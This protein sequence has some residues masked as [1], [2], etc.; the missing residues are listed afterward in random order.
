MRRGGA[1]RGPASP[2]KDVLEEGSRRQDDGRTRRAYVRALPPPSPR[3][4]L[5]VSSAARRRRRLPRRSIGADL[6]AAPRCDVVHRLRL[7]LR[8]LHTVARSTLAQRRRRRRHDA[9]ARLL[10]PALIFRSARRR[11]SPMTSVDDDGS[12]SPSTDDAPCGTARK[13]HRTP[14][15]RPPNS[16]RSRSSAR[17]PR[18]A[19]VHMPPS[20]SRK[21]TDGDAKRRFPSRL[22]GGR[23]RAREDA[24]SARLAA[25]CHRY[26]LERSRGKMFL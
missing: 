11:R 8:P 2:F 6:F 3:I 5:D 25:P 16:G 19:C 17:R 9:G 7:L 12:C 10:S 18:R 21:A 13:P 15:R 23:R 20:R 1:R 14:T 22:R 4:I 26:S 24:I